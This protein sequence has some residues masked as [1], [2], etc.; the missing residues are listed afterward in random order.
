MKSR[1]LVVVVGLGALLVGIGIGR[2]LGSRAAKPQKKEIAKIQP[3][4]VPLEKRAEAPVQEKASAR[5]A[6][7]SVK[8]SS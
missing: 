8:S 2:S 4:L 5:P 6:E 1:L 3:N 7:L